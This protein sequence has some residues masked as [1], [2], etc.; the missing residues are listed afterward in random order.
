MMNNL[1]RLSW[2]LGFL[3]VSLGLAWVVGISR[4]NLEVIIFKFLVFCPSVILVHL[5]R[6][7]LFPYID[8]KKHLDRFARCSGIAMTAA[9]IVDGS[10][11]LGVF[12]YYVVLIYALT[13][14][15]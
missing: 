8:L 11:I 15:I 10:V 9:A 3:A 2:P 14:A 12:L 4:T 5:S 13:Q 1:R 6:K 7:V